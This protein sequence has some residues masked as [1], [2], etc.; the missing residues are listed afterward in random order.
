VGIDASNGANPGEG[1]NNRGKF[2]LKKQPCLYYDTTWTP[3]PTPSPSPSPTPTQTSTKPSRPPTSPP[4]ATPT[5]TARPEPVSPD[6][7]APCKVGSGEEM[8][9]NC[10]HSVN[11]NRGMQCGQFYCLIKKTRSGIYRLQECS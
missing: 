7:C 8:V 3:T 11:R 4:T 6:E 5:S 2:F 10:P 1:G 9:F